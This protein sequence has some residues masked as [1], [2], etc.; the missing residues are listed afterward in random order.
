MLE[1]ITILEN[2]K[3]YKKEEE[4]NNIYQGTDIKIFDNRS[5]WFGW[6]KQ[7]YNMIAN[8]R[9]EIKQPNLRTII[10]IVDRRGNSGKSTFFKYMLAKEFPNDIARIG[11]GSAS[12]LRPSVTNIG[13]KKIYIIDLPRSKSKQDREE[14]LLSILEDIKIGLVIN[15]MYGV[16]N[17]LLM[18]P[19]HVIVASNY[20]PNYKLLSSDRWEMHEITEEKE[21]GEKNE[22]IKNEIKK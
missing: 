3:D 2:N 22:L 19:P 4:P 6:Q 10:S 17:T 21:L 14:D 12:Q 1:E 9:G 7:I 13:P 8:E 15:P 20:I 18:D 16:G 11:Y 5:N